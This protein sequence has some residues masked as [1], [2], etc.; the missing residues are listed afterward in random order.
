MNYEYKYRDSIGEVHTVT[1][2]GA[3]ILSDPVGHIYLARLSKTTYR[4]HYGLQ[5]K[6]FG[7]LE[8]A[9][10]EFGNCFL[11]AKAS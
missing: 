4:V 7:S 1:A 10:A 2:K 8:D 6:F 9:V 5:H 3:V 11:H